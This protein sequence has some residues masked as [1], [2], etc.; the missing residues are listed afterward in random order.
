MF[1]I[2]PTHMNGQDRPDG[3]CLLDMSD[4]SRNRPK[5][6]RLQTVTSRVRYRLPE[7]Y[8]GARTRWSSMSLDQ[9][10]AC[11]AGALYGPKWYGVLQ[12]MAEEVARVH[13]AQAIRSVSRTVASQVLTDAWGVLMEANLVRHIVNQ[14]EIERTLPEILPDIPDEDE[15]RDLTGVPRYQNPWSPP[16]ESR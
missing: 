3:K 9:E 8:P 16:D 13:D 6:Y 15:M 1:A 4:Y 14:D 12:R 7:D 2:Y 10:L 5:P 11:L